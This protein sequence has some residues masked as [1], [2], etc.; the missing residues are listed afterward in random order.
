MK[1]FQRNKEQL[2]KFLSDK[3]LQRYTAIVTI[4]SFFIMLSRCIFES[5]DESSNS[6]P[7]YENVGNETNEIN[8]NN[9]EETNNYYIMEEDEKPLSK[10][11]KKTYM[12]K[13]CESVYLTQHIENKTDIDIV[14]SSDN[15]ISLG[16]NGLFIPT[17]DNKDKFNF[18]GGTLVLNVDGCVKEMKEIRVSQ[19]RRGSK[20]ELEIVIKSEI[21][22]ILQDNFDLISKEIID[23]L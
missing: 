19:L 8:I 23:C 15:I 22:S 14:N 4:L 16:H 10:N 2:Y 13:G 17:N 5:E 7:I 1:N 18:S 9:K 11:R 3:R 21:C 12:L 6:N 20:E